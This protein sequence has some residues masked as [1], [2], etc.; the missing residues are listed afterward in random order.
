M[1][2]KTMC[3]IMEA[4]C[5]SCY[6]SIEGLIISICKDSQDSSG[7]EQMNQELNNLRLTFL[8]VQYLIPE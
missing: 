6:S 2:N 5:K 7:P 1:V 3:K 8:P 4:L